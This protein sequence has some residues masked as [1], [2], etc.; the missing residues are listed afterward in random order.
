MNS[1]GFRLS[2]VR[3]QVRLFSGFDW[4]SRLDAKTR[5]LCLLRL[6]YGYGTQWS[7]NWRGLSRKD[8][9]L[10]G[11]LYGCMQCI[12]VTREFPLNRRIRGWGRFLSGR[13]SHE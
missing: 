1:S 4:D 3:L 6:V 5:C 8:G 7:C 2:N 10:G 12:G 11:V 9:Y 13:L